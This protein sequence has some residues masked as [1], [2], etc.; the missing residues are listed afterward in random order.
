MDDDALESS[1]YYRDPQFILALPRRKTN[2][3]SA[4]VSGESSNKTKAEK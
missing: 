2:N 4:D 3:D 1:E